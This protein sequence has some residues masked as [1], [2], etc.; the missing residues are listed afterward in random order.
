MKIDE[1]A[2]WH[3]EKGFAV[4]AEPNEFGDVHLVAVF[5]SKED[6]EEYVRMKQASDDQ[7]SYDG[8]DQ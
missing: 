3:E 6:A 4:R 7:D 2:N 8:A 1:D 5:K